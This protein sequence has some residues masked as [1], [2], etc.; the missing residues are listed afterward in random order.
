MKIHTRTKKAT[1]KTSGG[2]V[3]FGASRKSSTN[4][5]FFSKALLKRGDDG[6]GH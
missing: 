5:R 2:D 4:A 1:S 3:D 6:C